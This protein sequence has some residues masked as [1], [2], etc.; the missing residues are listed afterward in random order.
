MATKGQNRQQIHK[1]GHNFSYMRHINDI[2]AKFGF[3][4]GFQLSAN[5]WHSRTQ[6]LKADTHYPYVR[7]VHTGRIYGCI[8]RYPY[9]RAVKTARM[10]GPYVRLVRIGL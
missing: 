6:G 3:E 2:N 10:H 8:F 4:I 5:S 1:N 9:V 7:P